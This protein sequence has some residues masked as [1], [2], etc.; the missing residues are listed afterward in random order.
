MGRWSNHSE[1]GERLQALVELVPSGPIQPIVRTKKQNQ[2][3]L[4]PAEIAELV[5]G[6]RDGATVY[7]L[8][9]RFRVHRDT[10]SKLLERQGVARRGRPLSPFQID[11]AVSLYAGGQS[12][13]KIAPQLECDPGTVRL[14]L[15]KTGV[16]LRDCHGRDRHPGGAKS[17]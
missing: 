11:Q 9:K 1:Q 13:A 3:R 10:V 16:R 2:T 5:V 17:P 12:L 14:A 6:Y 15:I 7:E 8:A 4:R